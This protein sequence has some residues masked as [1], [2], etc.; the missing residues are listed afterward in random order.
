VH[1]GAHKNELLGFKKGALEVKISAPPEKG[2]A[3]QELIE[4]LSK[5]L[6]LPK[7][8]ITLLKGQASRLKLLVIEG[9]TQAELEQRLAP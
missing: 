1:P 4:F 9:V 2:K 7:S 3:N 8:R 6:G 5:R